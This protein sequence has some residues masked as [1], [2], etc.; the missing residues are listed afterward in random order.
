[1][2]ELKVIRAN[3]AASLG[4]RL[5]ASMLLVSLTGC[6]G[7]DPKVPGSSSLSS[8]LSGGSTGTDEQRTHNQWHPDHGRQDLRRL[9]LPAGSDRPG[10]R[11]AHV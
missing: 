7:D 2:L 8:Q 4:A 10:R 1:M 6:L 11:H 3:A 9:F 5:V